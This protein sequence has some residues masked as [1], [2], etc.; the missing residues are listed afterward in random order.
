MTEIGD[1]LKQVDKAYDKA[2]N[3]LVDGTGSLISRTENLRKLGAKT[4]KQLPKEL[5]EEI[6]VQQ[7]EKSD[8]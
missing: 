4:T 6:A 5:V 3:K 7:L 2:K 1:R 8:A